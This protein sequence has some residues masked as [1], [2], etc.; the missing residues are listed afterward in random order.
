M[1]RWRG[2]QAAGGRYSGGRS[3]G[4]GLR[5]RAVGE[6]HQGRYQGVGRLVGGGGAT[7]RMMGDDVRR[8]VGSIGRSGDVEAPGNR[9]AGEGAVAVHRDG[10]VAA[11]GGGVRSREIIIKCE[12]FRVGQKRRYRRRKGNDWFAI[13]KIHQCRAPTDEIMPFVPHLPWPHKFI[14]PGPHQRIYAV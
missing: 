3:Q 4:T 1:R 8:P 10:G 14:S 13:P 6:W 9:W 7:V 5:R 11:T 2:G 12:K